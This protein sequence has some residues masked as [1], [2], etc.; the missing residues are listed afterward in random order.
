MVMTDEVDDDTLARDMIDVHGSMA[1]GVARDNAR[2][3]ALAGQGI[4][5]R[6]WIR[7][8][9]LIQRRQGRHTSSIRPAAGAPSGDNRGRK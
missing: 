9:S 7:V 6:S 5:A 4:Q 3:A 8:L 2:S 1:A